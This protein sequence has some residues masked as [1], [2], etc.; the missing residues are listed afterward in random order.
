MLDG[1]VVAIT[2]ASS[3]I[4]AAIA[5]VLAGRGAK[6]VLGARRAERLEALAA[7]IIAD[8][9]D[10]AWT[11]T[12]V[13][14]RADLHG[15]VDLA[16]SRYGRL[17][18]LVGNAGIMPVSPLDELR[19]DEWD[20]MVD[21]NIKGILHGIGAALPVFRAQ[22]AGQ[23]VHIASTSGHRTVPGQAVYSGTKFAVRAISEGLRQEAGPDLRVTIV[24]PGITHTEFSRTMESPDL[25]ARLVELRDRIAMPPE[26]VARAV[27][28]AIEQPA[29]IDLNEVI[30]RPTAQA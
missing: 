26:A 18:V 9:G 7:R 29:D 12:D 25:R 28:Y 17:D 5:A 6:V 19:V 22:G 10:V 27:A 15:L 23:F 8:G 4:G 20:D 3:G 30:I 1:K 21:V 16:R 11:V 24:S 13:R 2:G 14:R